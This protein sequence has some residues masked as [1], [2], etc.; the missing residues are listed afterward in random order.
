MPIISVLRGA[1]LHMEKCLISPDFA[2]FR[3][4]SRLYFVEGGYVF[5]EIWLKLARDS[6]CEKVKLVLTFLRNA[7]I[8]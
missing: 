1:D 2:T 5:L 6:I 3:S 8:V 7:K 4:D